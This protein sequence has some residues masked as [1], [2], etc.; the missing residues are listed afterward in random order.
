MKEFIV[1]VD[2][3]YEDSVLVAILESILGKDAIFCD[4][5]IT[6]K[7]DRTIDEETIKKIWDNI[8]KSGP[9][10]P[11]KVMYSSSNLKNIEKDIRNYLQFLI[12]EYEKQED[13]K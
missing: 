6:K 1:K 12:P 7:K 10:E 9:D 11:F 3:A 2:S 5:S 4:A 13:L 8:S